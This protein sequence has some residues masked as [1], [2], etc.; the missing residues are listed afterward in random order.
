MNARKAFMLA[1]WL[2]ATAPLSAGCG[3]APEAALPTPPAPA[4]A[5]CPDLPARIDPA[6]LVDAPAEPGPFTRH[7]HADWRRGTELIEVRWLPV[8]EMELG[9]LH[10]MLVYTDAEG[11]QRVIAAFPKDD[12]DPLLRTGDLVVQISAFEP[13]GRF[14]EDLSEH[15][16]R[17]IVARSRDGG[18]DLSGAWAA[19]EQLGATIEQ[20][21][22]DY[23]LL[24]PNSNSAVVTILKYAGVPPLE[25]D[26]IDDPGARTDL[27]ALAGARGLACTEPNQRVR[28]VLE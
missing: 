14:G 2:A 16:L 10:Q 20:L 12:F 9:G 11:G 5:A 18:A 4:R 21:G 19:M 1:L 28:Q 17:Q 23:F 24:G 25:P 26:P 13:K 8:L 15:S 6:L 22:V 7:T 3:P 27:F